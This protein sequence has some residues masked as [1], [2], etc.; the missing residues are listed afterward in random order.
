MFGI[1]SGNSARIISELK[2]Y[3]ENQGLVFKKVNLNDSSP[4]AILSSETSIGYRTRSKWNKTGVVF[5]C[6]KTD[7]NNLSRQLSLPI[8]DNSSDSKRPYAVFI[9][10]PKIKNAVEIL[11][12]NPDNSITSAPSKGRT[13]NGNSYQD[14]YWIPYFDHVKK[15]LLRDGYSNSDSNTETTVRDTFYLERKDPRDFLSWFK[16]ELTLQEA[17]ERVIELLTAAK[18]KSSNLRND[19][20]YYS[21]DLDYF[22]EF[23]WQ[24]RIDPETKSKYEILQNLKNKDNVTLIRD[25]NNGRLCVR[26]K[27]SVYNYDVFIKLKESNFYGIPKLIEINKSGDTLYTIEEYIDGK[28]LYEIVNEKGILEEN[29]AGRIIME[30]CR[31]LKQFHHMIPQL[32]HRDIKPSNI[33]LTKDGQVFLIDFN[34]SKE[35]RKN[36]SE[37]T[38]LYGT[39]Y[40]AAPEQLLGYGSSSP[41]T[42]IYGLGATLNYLITGLYASQIISPG[43]YKSVIEKSVKMDPENRYQSIEEFEQAISAI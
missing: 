10:E 14:K 40:F 42:D 38:V 19:I 37:D 30:L 13:R 41:A 12:Q 17:K 15:C 4:Y 18:R 39:Q 11:K 24:N 33:I 21:R 9:P 28:T 26:K 32:I 43:R 25:R 29:E 5:F 36:T 20:K 3:M 23:L 34:A 7:A 6:C 2:D 16:D 35:A 27:Y 22:A 1:E 8:D 31:I